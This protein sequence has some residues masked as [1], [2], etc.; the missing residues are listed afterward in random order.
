MYSTF[1]D[2]EKPYDTIPRDVYWCLRNGGVEIYQKALTESGQSV[3]RQRR[4]DFGMELGIG[5][6]SYQY[7]VHCL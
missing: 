2:F 5:C 7:S 3:K 1:I 4:L 6:I